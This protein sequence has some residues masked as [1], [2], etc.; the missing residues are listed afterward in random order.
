M[1]QS[2]LTFRGA[3]VATLLVAYLVWHT[4]AAAPAF[5]VL[6]PTDA[7]LDLIGVTDLINRLGAS[8]P[9]GAGIPVSHVEAGGYVSD[10]GVTFQ[11]AYTP[12]TTQPFFAGRDFTYKSG[13]SVSTNHA[14]NIGAHW[15]GNN[16]IA[17]GVTDIDLYSAERYWGA[18]L[19]QN[20]SKL[21]PNV[22]TQRVQNHSWIIP[23]GAA[24]TSF[25]IDVLR[26][27]DYMLDRDGV[28]AAVG[29]NNG[30]TSL[31]PLGLANSY[32]SIAVGHT[33]GRS[34][35]GPTTLDTTGRSK[36]D[37]VAPAR[38]VSEATS[39]I[40]AATTLLLETAGSNTHAAH[41]ETIKA[42]MLAGAT[43]GE[44]DLSGATGSTLD[45]W[46]HT[47]Q[48]PLDFRY[49]AGELNVDN[50]HRI[51]SAGEFEGGASDVGIRGWDFDTIEAGE[52]KLYFFDVHPNATIDSLSIIATWNREFDVDTKGASAVFNPL[53]ANIDMRL[54]EAD[55]FT[56]GT[57]LDT[58]ANTID[59]VEHIYRE[60]MAG[61]RFAIEVTSDQTWDFSLAWQTILGTAAPGDANYDGQINGL[62][63]LIWADHYG[64]TMAAFS[65]GDFNGD[66]T[67]DVFDLLL[68]VENYSG[69]PGA[70]PLQTAI[71]EPSSA[72]LA[73]VG[74]VVL[75]LRR[76]RQQLRRGK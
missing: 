30:S 25:T 48:Q 28:V 31:F 39:W 41:P 32:N 59:N 43:K 49:G 34:S 2:L 44:F 8:A 13:P 57:I 16:G 45:D 10:D 58:S 63:Y 71:P 72:L 6:G 56:L 36:P 66:Q 40:S 14:T 33:T 67:V 37:I 73:T 22:E 19:L 7:E 3:R 35:L 46:S 26:R 27:F 15:Y 21:L 23:A 20:G 70:N 51:L 54:Y 60:D 55:G 24:S 50:S 74:L 69:A 17:P 64:E 65:D 75:T 76:R 9:T 29:V 61:G 42:A 4:V 53:L 52:P 38:H 62:D 11:Y 1:P 47:T 5:A 18:D 68:W 12:E